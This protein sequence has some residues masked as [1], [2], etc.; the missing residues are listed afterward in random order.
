M[1]IMVK[2]VESVIIDSNT[3]RFLRDLVKELTE[4]ACELDDEIYE[5]DNLRE[6][7]KEFLDSENVRVE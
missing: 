3:A 5:V 1:N 4:V 2:R 7:I 6:A